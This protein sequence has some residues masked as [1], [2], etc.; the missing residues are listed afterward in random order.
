MNVIL[1][2]DEALCLEMLCDVCRSV[3]FQCNGYL[4]PVEAVAEFSR[5]IDYF[6]VLITDIRMPEM[7]GVEVMKALRGLRPDLPMIFVTAHSDY[8]TAVEAIKEQA[9]A[10]LAKPVDIREMIA[11]LQSLEPKT[12]EFRRHRENQAQIRETLELLQKM[13]AE[14]TERLA[15]RKSNGKRK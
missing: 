9:C 14:I 13:S 6:D 7:D 8:D 3:G 15:V 2:D 5:Q 1:I 12:Q 11:I 4:S 10:Y